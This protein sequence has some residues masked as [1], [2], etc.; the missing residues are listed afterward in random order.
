[1][2]GPRSGGIEI[3]SHARRWLITRPHRV[4][5][6][7]SDRVLPI[8]EAERLV[9]TWWHELGESSH[10]V[11]LYED[12]A[13]SVVRPLSEVQI[14]SEVL[15]RIFQAIR[16]HEVVVLKTSLFDEPKKR[17]DRPIVSRAPAPA[18]SPT[19]PR[20]GRLIKEKSFLD[21]SVVNEQGDPLGGTLYKVQLPDGR[22]EQGE[23]DGSARVFKPN[24]DPGTARFSLHKSATPPI[25]VDPVDP[26]EQA[27]WISFRVLNQDGDPLA[28]VRYE[29]T[30]PDGN[31]VSGQTDDS[32]AVYLADVAPG[33]C[34]LSLPDLPDDSWSL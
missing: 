21:V 3:V 6:E 28:G 18:P 27:G 2:R 34:E 5:P 8:R 20:I 29:L 7:Q 1:M 14:D 9:S 13:E 24:I 31:T 26:D 17:D 25:P 12:L 4:R 22:S 11:D 16:D 19:T 30:L 33:E 15:P 32:G 23:L 10:I